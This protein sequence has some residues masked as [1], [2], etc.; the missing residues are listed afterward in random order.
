[1]K[2]V[3]AESLSQSYQS[4]YQLFCLHRERPWS[5]ELFTKTIN[6]NHAIFALI[7]E[8]VVGYAIFSVVCNEGELEDICVSPQHRE[9]GIAAAL[10]NEMLKQCKALDSQYVLLEVNQHNKAALALYAALKFEQVGVRKNYYAHA[11]GSYSN[12]LVMRHML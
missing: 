5:Y 10:L 12:A 2:I 1:M 11:N 8:Q 7:N 3:C 4:A 6:N 9:K